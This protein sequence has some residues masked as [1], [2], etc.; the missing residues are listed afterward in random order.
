M[1]FHLQRGVKSRV[2]VGFRLRT[3]QDA[4][5]LAATCYLATIRCCLFV[6]ALLWL[7]LVGSGGGLPEYTSTEESGMC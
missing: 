4:G 7:H 5:L 2:S 1:G 6:L 3:Q